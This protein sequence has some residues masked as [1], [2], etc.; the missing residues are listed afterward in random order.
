MAGG[1]LEERCACAEVA[2]VVLVVPSTAAS[3]SCLLA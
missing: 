2:G 3:C 1:E